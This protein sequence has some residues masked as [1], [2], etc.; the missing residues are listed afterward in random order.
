MEDKFFDD[1]E[2][3]INNVPDNIEPVAFKHWEDRWCNGLQSQERSHS[4]CWHNKKTL[5]D[6]A[7]M[8]Q[9][10]DCGGFLDPYDTLKRLVSQKERRQRYNRHLREEFKEL[11]TKVHSSKKELKSLDEKIRRRK[12][13]LSEV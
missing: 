2:S 9:C 6:D 11:S 1:L 3:E 10:N 12:N 5:N 13:N 8:V 7:R 4:D